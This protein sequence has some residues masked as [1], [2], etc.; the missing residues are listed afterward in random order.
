MA[1][2]QALGRSSLW[3]GKTGWAV[4]RVQCQATE[5]AFTIYVE[6]SQLLIRRL[7]P[8]CSQLWAQL[9]ATTPG[10]QKFIAS[11]M[12]DQDVT[13]TDPHGCCVLHTSTVGACPL[14]VPPLNLALNPDPL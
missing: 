13:P 6:G 9:P 10:P 12:I 3:E 8:Q 5:P 1:E 11:A 2:K 14:A 4:V 7:S